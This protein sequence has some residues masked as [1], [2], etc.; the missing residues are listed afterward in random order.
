V[1]AGQFWMVLVSLLVGFLVS[2]IPLLLF[3]GYRV[4]WL[5]LVAACM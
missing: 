4:L 5:L 1:V 2:R 3:C